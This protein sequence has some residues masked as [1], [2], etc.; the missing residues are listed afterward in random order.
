MYDNN[1]EITEYINIL[2][3]DGRI[4]TVINRHTVVGDEIP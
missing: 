1:V 3:V 4:K 2:A